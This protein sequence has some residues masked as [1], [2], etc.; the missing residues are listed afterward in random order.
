MNSHNSSSQ[1]TLCSSLLLQDRRADARRRCRAAVWILDDDLTRVT[2][3]ATAVDISRGGVALCLHTDET[4]T[5]ESLHPGREWLVILDDPSGLEPLATNRTA[6][7]RLLRSDCDG[8]GNIRIACAF[9]ARQVG[10]CL[11]K[12]AGAGARSAEPPSDC[13]AGDLLDELAER[14]ARE[15]TAEQRAQR[16]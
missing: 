5:L 1:E 4:L 6:I 7:I 11:P 16:I 15:L 8:H 3:F 13:I 2:E 14:L 10:R 9:A 12:R